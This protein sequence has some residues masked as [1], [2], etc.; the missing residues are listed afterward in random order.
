V[1]LVGQVVPVSVETMKIVG[2]LPP[3]GEGAPKTE[4]TQADLDAAHI[5]VAEDKPADS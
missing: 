1:R 4:Y 5:Y 2:S 3:L